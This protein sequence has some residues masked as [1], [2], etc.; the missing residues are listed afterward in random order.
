MDALKRKYA[1]VREFIARDLW[2]LDEDSLP[3][4]KRKAC[5]FLKVAYIV[6]RGFLRDNCFTFIIAD[7]PQYGSLATVPFCPR[8]TSATAYF[9]FHGRNTRNW[10]RKGIETS[11]RYAYEYSDDEL[12][13]FA[14]SIREIAPR[15]EATYAMFNNCHGGFAMKNALRMKHMLGAGTHGKNEEQTEKTT[16]GY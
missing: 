12:Q 13:E 10:L 9:R 5:A 16:S 1:T 7:E 4:T 14:V 2:V 6:I 15:A 8:L 11:L 3:A